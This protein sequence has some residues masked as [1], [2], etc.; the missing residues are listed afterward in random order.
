LDE[1]VYPLRLIFSPI[2]S[3]FLKLCRYH[4]RNRFQILCRKLSNRPFCS[5]R[6]NNMISPIRHATLFFALYS[7]T[8]IK[9]EFVPSLWLIIRFAIRFQIW[10]LLASFIFLN[11]KINTC[12]PLRNTV[13]AL[14][15]LSN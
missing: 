9:L 15:H 1:R 4:I 7:I 14:S 11:Y 3:I 10:L 13:E 6:L 8:F 2:A 5:L 12:N